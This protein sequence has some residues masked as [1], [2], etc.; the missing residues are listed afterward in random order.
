[1]KYIIQLASEKGASSWLNA[2][3]LS[4]HDFHLTKNEFRDGIAVRYTWEA[5]NTPAKCPCGTNSTSPMPYIAPKA[6]IR[7]YDTTK[8]ETCLQ[9]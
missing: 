3:P 4:K 2:F 8:S 5:K 7:T 1:M 6:G 9:T